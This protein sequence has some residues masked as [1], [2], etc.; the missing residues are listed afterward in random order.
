MEYFFLQCSFLVDCLR[1]EWCVHFLVVLRYC[2]LNNVTFLDAT[3]RKLN[4]L[5]EILR[6]LLCVFLFETFTQSV[7]RRWSV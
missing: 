3:M 6:N 1:Y 4:V 5:L 2:S 7:L